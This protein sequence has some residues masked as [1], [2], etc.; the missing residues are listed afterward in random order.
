MSVDRPTERAGSTG[1]LAVVAA[2][3]ALASLTVGFGIVDL[4]SPWI[5][6][7]DTQVSDVGYG[8]L[9]GLVIPVGLLAQLHRPARRVAGVQQVAAAALACL[10]AGTLARERP[11]LVAGGIVAGAVVLVAALHPARR[12]LLARPRP[13]IPLLVLA[14]AACLPGSQ[15]VLHMACN[16]RDGVLPADAHLG[17]QH[18]A[19]LAAAALAVLFTAL[20]AAVRTEGFAIPAFTASV[21]CSRGR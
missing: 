8:A 14:L 5:L 1:A 6:H 17:L 4:L 3:L 10:V 7:E 11:L 21:P 16:E 18:W 9:A 19:A 15:Y 13:S 20:V 2:G 12:S